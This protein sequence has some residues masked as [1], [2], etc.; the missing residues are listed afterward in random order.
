ML[1]FVSDERISP[2]GDMHTDRHDVVDAEE[3][4]KSIDNW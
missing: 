1:P 4:V 3:E 2:D